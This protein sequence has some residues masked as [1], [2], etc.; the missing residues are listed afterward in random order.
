MIL[1]LAPQVVRRLRGHGGGRMDQTENNLDY[2]DSKY[3]NLR[4]GFPNE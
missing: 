3:E 1:M 4:K 2:P